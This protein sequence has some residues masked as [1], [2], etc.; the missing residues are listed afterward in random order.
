[1][2]GK[3]V[4]RSCEDID[5][6]TLSYAE[7]KAVATGNPIIKEKMEI[8]NDVQRLKLLKASYNSQRY[9]LQD[10]YMVRF[11]K[12]IKE[13][14][15][16]LENVRD[17]IKKR[18]EELRKGAE[19]AVT[20]EGRVIAERVEAGTLLLKIASSCKAGDSRHI[21]EFRSFE[22]WIE[23]DIMNQEY[24][25]LRGKSDY[26]VEL[27]TSPVGNMV[28]LENAFHDMQ[29]HETFLLNKLEQYENDLI[30]SKAEYEKPFQYEDEYKLKLA[31]QAEINEQ[32]DLENKN[33][34]DIEPDNIMQKEV[35]E[36][37]EP[38]ID[39]M[40]SELLCSPAQACR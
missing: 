1:M 14:K 4:S 9:M 37:G 31:R 36:S 3:S 8:D 28:K 34:S 6:T 33:I 19:F 13:A 7:I 35:E 2:T 17:D 39:I 10:N 23:H 15:E 30:S 38:S 11:P 22:L 26:K 24:M 27:S 29:Q 20:L 25:I 18:D 16:K 40:E 21:G 32:L 5:E 12:L